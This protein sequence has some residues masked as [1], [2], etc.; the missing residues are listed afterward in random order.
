MGY[1]KEVNQVK[2]FQLF[3]P[4]VDRI[5]LF[6]LSMSFFPTKV[7][8]DFLPLLLLADY[9]AAWDDFFCPQRGNMSHQMVN[10]AVHQEK[11][12]IIST[13]GMSPSTLL[14]EVTESDRENGI[15]CVTPLQ[16]LIKVVCSKM[17][18]SFISFLFKFYVHY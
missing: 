10:D 1:C 8:V 3:S 15:C 18:F 4:E 5:I 13:P 14:E 12:F 6:T 9:V 17:F 2:D 7:S 16:R 11:A